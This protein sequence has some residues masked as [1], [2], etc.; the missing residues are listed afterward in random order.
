MPQTALAGLRVLEIGQHIAVPYCAKLLGDLGADVIKIE[1]PGGDPLRHYG[2]FPNDLP[3]PEK[4]ALFHYLNVNKRGAVMDLA[5]EQDRARAL[6]LAADAD[7]VIEGLRVGQLA[8]WGLD[9][10]ALAAVNP[11][12]ALVQ[13]SGFGQ[14]GPYPSGP[15]STSSCKPRVPGSPGTGSRTPS[16]C[17]SEVGSPNTSPAPTPQRPAFRRSSPQGS[18]VAPCTS[19]YR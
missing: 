6:E 10:E 13:V 18:R 2:P 17:A 11:Q 14:S 15:A 1:R 7:L 4:S 12:V 8:D 5:R 3:D 16:R 9:F 19:T